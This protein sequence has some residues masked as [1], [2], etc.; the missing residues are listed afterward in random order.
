MRFLIMILLLVGIRAQAQECVPD[1]GP[2][3]EP[4][5]GTLVIARDQ[6]TM[7]LDWTKPVVTNDCEPLPN[8]IDRYE[9]YVEEAQGEPNSIA[10]LVIPGDQ[11]A[12]V[13]SI[14]P[15][16]RFHIM[17]R[18]CYVADAIDYC[19]FWS[20]NERVI[21]RGHR[22]GSSSRSPFPQEVRHGD[23][24]TSSSLV[25]DGIQ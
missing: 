18:A 8:D 23:N 24:F 13:Q 25:G 4:P 19:S 22:G 16:K 12:S 20:Q 17:F 1:F 11:L 14:E 21:R 9:L 2:G 3:A 5:D 7:A 10:T 6:N 15:G